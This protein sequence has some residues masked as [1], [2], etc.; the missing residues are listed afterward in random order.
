MFMN[1]KLV[2]VIVYGYY[3]FEI[4]SSGYVELFEVFGDKIYLVGFVMIIN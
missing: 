4:I 2:C 3:Y 1:C